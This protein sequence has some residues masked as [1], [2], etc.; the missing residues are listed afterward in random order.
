M[1]KDLIL[2]VIGELY[3]NLLTKSQELLAVT[4]ERDLLR[5][6]VEQLLGSGKS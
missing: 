6:Q 3:L 2:K 5:E 1:D 4:K